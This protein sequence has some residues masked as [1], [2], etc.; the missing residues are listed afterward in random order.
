VIEVAGLPTGDV[1]RDS[2]QARESHPIYGHGDPN[3]IQAI[4]VTTEGSAAQREISPVAIFVMDPIANPDIKI[5]LPEGWTSLGHNDFVVDNVGYR[6]CYRIVTAPGTQT[7][8]CTW[9]DDSTSS[10]RARWWSSECG[11]LRLPEVAPAMRV[12]E[13]FARCARTNAVAILLAE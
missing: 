7:A 10:P 2:G 6:A 4:T 12:D 11:Q 5:S 9:S 1:I 13:L 8:T 3:S